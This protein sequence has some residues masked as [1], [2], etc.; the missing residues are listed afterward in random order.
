MYETIHTVVFSAGEGGGNPAPVT[1]NADELTPGQMQAMAFDFG[2]ESVFL[3]SSG[4][5][6]CDFRPRFFVPLHEMEMCI[7]ATIGSV[8]VLVEKGLVQSSP[9]YY[10]TVYGPVRIDWS[11]KEDGSL[12][13]GVA[14]FLPKVLEKAPDR[15]E[16]SRALRIS[17]DELGSGPVRSVATS[18]Y[19]LIVPLKHRK[20]LDALEPDF[21]YLWELCDKYETTGFYPF[22]PEREADGSVEFCA[23]QF[24]K[25]AGYPEDPATGVAASALGA[26]LAMNQFL[27]VREG[28]NSYEIRQGEAMGR[29]SRIISDIYVEN[30][31]ITKT[32][33]RGSAY[34][35][36]E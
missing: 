11:R 28:W 16:I 22:A 34:L 1:L 26:Y 3:C 29:P 20:T 35:L 12:D 10:E 31:Q 19:K 7:H 17:E 33:V 32:R 21:E 14:Q 30:G 25:R 24:P 36:K 2:E 13:I 5:E 4:R 18:R 6:D 9:V 23:R 15:E 8:T 27:P